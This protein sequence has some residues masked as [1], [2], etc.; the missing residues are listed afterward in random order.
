MNKK[1]KTCWVLTLGIPGM[2]NQSLGLAQ[3]LGLEVEQKR[4]CLTWLWWHLPSRFCFSP[5]R[6]L[7][8]GSSDF[9][10]P[11]PDVVIGTGRRTVAVALAIKKASGGKT[12]NIRI[13]DPYYAYDKFDVI[14]AP[15]HDGL[16][17][18][19]ILNSIGGLHTITPARLKLAAEHFAQ[20]FADLPRP[21]VAVMVGGSN[22]CYRMTAQIGRQLGARLAALSKETGAGI[23]LTTSRRTDAE[24]EAVLR[25]ELSDTPSF[26]WDGSGEN[27][28]LGFLSLADAILVTADS[29]NMVSEACT[30]GKPVYV[31]EL[32]GGSD[33]FNRF[34]QIMQ[35]EGYTRPFRGKLENWTYTP[36][37]DVGN[38]ARE[39]GRR[40]N[41]KANSK[42]D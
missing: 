29:V 10:P 30:T 4:I 40:L 6:F 14:V 15:R 11:W 3:A 35:S 19:N 37:D 28:Y 33:K 20:Q 25:E 34:H 22:K 24:V 36:L 23:L 7:G 32:D 5:L 27:P 1:V 42:I 39:I 12:F 13:Q 17:G 9:S 38:A 41:L 31:I 8:P 2:D 21:L 16:S 18:P 26:I